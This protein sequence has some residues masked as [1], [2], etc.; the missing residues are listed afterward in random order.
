MALAHDEEWGDW[1]FHY[2]PEDI[3]GPRVIPPSF[4]D[5]L[6]R[7]VLSSSPFLRLMEVSVVKDQPRPEWTFRVT[8]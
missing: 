1:E 7:F 8:K 2:D 6:E 5:S 4:L 3:W